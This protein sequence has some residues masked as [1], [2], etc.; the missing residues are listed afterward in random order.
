VENV[1][2]SEKQRER[3]KRGDG[4]EQL[5]VEHLERTGF[6]V[7]GRNVT[8]RDGELDIVAMK[9]EVLAFVEVRMRMS[10]RFGHPAE[11]ISRSKRQKII[12]AALRFLQRHNLFQ[13][14]IRFDVATVTG[15]GSDAALEYLSDAFDAER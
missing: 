7:I 15:I 4:A 14:V 11:T 3:K 9:G 5:V 8:F 13:R 6:V 2:E 10:H 12:R 1:D